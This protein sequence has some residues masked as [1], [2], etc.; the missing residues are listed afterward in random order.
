[1][2]NGLT[3]LSAAIEQ[4]SQE[5]VRFLT[6]NGFESQ[7]VAVFSPGITGKLLRGFEKSKIGYRYTAARTITPIQ[8]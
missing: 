1:L 8:A 4:D 5:I 3:E 2:D 7:E 6:E